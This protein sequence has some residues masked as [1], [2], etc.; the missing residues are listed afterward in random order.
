MCCIIPHGPSV[1][2]IRRSI[3]TDLVCSFQARIPRVQLDLLQGESANH[4]FF[5]SQKNKQKTLDF[6]VCV[7]VCVC[8]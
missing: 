6:G 2:C 8:V 5:H 1:H 7:C 4:D 3:L